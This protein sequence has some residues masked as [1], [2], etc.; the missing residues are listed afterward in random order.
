MTPPPHVAFREDFSLLL[1]KPQGALGEHE[2]NNILAFIAEEEALSDAAEL[3]FIDTSALTA[4]DL[5][6]NYVFHVS[7]YRRLTR[8]NRPSLKTACF[9]NDE[10]FAHY[11]KLHLMMTDHSPLQVRI[12]HDR[13]E[14]AQWL[15]VPVEGLEMEEGS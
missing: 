14:A 11:F 5:N 9:V 7:L 6:F 13:A 1:W 4:V 15:G 10:A 3:R 12:F 2:V 8:T